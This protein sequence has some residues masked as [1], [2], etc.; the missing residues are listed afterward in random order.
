MEKKPKNTAT[1][2][3]LQNNMLRVI[4]GFKLQNRVNMKNLRVEI[5]MMSVNQISVYH[6]LLEAYNVMRHLSSKQINIK[7]KLIE[8]KYALRSTTE[9]QL[10]VPEKPKLKCLDFTYNGAK[11][12][13]ML[14]IQMRGPKNSNTFKTMTKDWIWKNIPSY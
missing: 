13:N 4:F 14:P 8:R 9:K 3:T 5:K 7:W 2:Q 12:F 6:T 1:L 11:L 10:N